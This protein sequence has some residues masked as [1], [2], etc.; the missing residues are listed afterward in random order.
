MPTL[1][2]KTQ[3][4][5]TFGGN[6]AHVPHAATMTSLEIESVTGSRHDNVK[7]TIETLAAKGV[8]SLPQTEGV[9]VQRERR[10]ETVEA[11]LFTGDKGRRDSIIVVA[12]LC[13]E[14][15]ARIVD[16]WQELEAQ[17]AKPVQP[18]VAMP[19]LNTDEGKLL[20]IRDLATKQL[21]LLA[22]NKR[23]ATE[24]AITVPKA[25]ALDRIAQADGDM[26]ITVAAKELGMQPRKLTAWMEQ[27]KWIYRRN[28]A[29][30][31]IAYQDRIQSGHLTHK[32]TTVQRKD[33][34][35]KIVS[36]VIV[37]PKGLTKL[38]EV[39]A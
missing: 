38:A 32:V 2:S 31:P 14:Y 30:K 8:I 10:T 11:Y 23:I 27:H 20:M 25:Q 22:D 37:T 39:A 29:S 36:Q 12:Q 9:K 34:S 19:D 33:G 15:T 26:C 18:P 4:A 3:I 13:P 16:R 24:L 1:P 7:R 17:L 21:A 35:D 5:L 6:D 28:G